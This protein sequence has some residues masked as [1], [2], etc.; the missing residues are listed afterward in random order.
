MISRSLGAPAGAAV[1]IPLFFA[2]ALSL[3]FYSVG[4]ASSLLVLLPDP[5]S[6]PILSYIID[7]R[8]LAMISCVA[9]CGLAL[10]SAE[11]AIKAQYFVMGA[12]GLSLLSLLLGGFERSVSEVERF[13]DAAEAKAVAEAKAAKLAE[14]ADDSAAQ[15]S[16][17]AHK[18]EAAQ[19]RTTMMRVILRRAC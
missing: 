14:T 5:G 10:R 19:A 3:S 9:L 16:L 11:A 4:F 13:I 8:F 1:G 7:I 12:I 6:H 15:E 17:E 2:Q 18:A